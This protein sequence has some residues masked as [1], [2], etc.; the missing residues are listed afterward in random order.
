MELARTTSPDVNL[1]VEATVL[2]YTYTGTDPIEVIARIDIGDNSKPII[3]GGVYTVNFYVN[4]IMV[5]PNTLDSV[6]GGQT[7]TIVVS[8]PV[9]ISLNDVITLKVL[10]LLGDTA[11]NTV[12]S[13][14]SS[15][16][17]QKTDIYGTGP[18]AVDHN[19]GGS[20]ALSYKTAGGAG[21]A[22]ATIFCYRTVDYN[23]GNRGQAFLQ[24]RSTTVAG[25]AWQSPMYLSAG[26]YTL[27]YTLPGQY[28]PDVA[29][30][31]V[32]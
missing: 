22:G 25:G 28:G 16:P 31:T 2:S 19:Y 11:V 7:R 29:A 4:G 27:V 3:G 30:I 8:R 26:T 13:L 6:P 21:V 23:A 20:E 17:V 32:S 9:P 15:T 18:I 14:R 12:A 1:S 10:G 24:A 5:T